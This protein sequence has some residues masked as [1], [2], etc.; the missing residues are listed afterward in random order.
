MIK[1]SINVTRINKDR[2]KPGKNGKYLDLVL[3]DKPDQYGN[4]G[5]VCED[6][7]KEQ[8]E[9]GER[10][11]IVGN[12]KILGSKRQPDSSPKPAPAAANQSSEDDENPF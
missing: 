2:I 3:F 12:W 1:L 11:T 5:F 7:T 4:A 9:A 6:V 10:G 8:R